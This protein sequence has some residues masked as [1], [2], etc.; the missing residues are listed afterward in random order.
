[1]RIS[2]GAGIIAV[3]WLGLGSWDHDKIPA[4]EHSQGGCLGDQMCPGAAVLAG[5]NK[6]HLFV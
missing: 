4:G 2:L 1:M 5:I 6:S 3:V